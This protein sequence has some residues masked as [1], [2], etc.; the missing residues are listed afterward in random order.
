V[1][2]LI[3]ALLHDRNSNP[4]AANANPSIFKANSG[5]TTVRKVTLIWVIHSASHASWL[6]QDRLDEL[7]Q[8][9]LD[10]RIPP[11]TVTHGRPDLRAMVQELVFASGD[12][13]ND[14]AI[15]TGVVVSGP[16]AL[17]RDVRNTCSKLVSEGMDVNV[18]VEKFG[19]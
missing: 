11:P 8:L 14:T 16:D 6:P 15:S 2:P 13:H 3:W 19:W 5:T 9:G 17:N 7:V 12:A 4:T 1:F 10:V 18:A